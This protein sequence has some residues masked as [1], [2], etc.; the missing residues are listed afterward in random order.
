MVSLESDQGTRMNILSAAI[1]LKLLN[2]RNG[3]YL[4]GWSKGQEAFEQNFIRF[5]DESTYEEVGI[6]AEPPEAEGGPA[7]RHGV[8]EASKGHRNYYLGLSA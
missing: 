2:L 6:Y 5:L 7:W 1:D 3:E 4:D 8:D